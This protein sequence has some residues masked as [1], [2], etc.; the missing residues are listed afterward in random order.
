MFVCRKWILFNNMY[1]ERCARSKVLHEYRSD[2]HD[3]GA[4]DHDD[5]D[6]GTDNEQISE[7]TLQF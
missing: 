2:W 4:A 6:A 7:G 5:N 1:V 3:K